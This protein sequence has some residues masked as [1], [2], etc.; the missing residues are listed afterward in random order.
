METTEVVKQNGDAATRGISRRTVMKGAAWS[1]PVIA[2]AAA[3]PMATA[4]C[5]PTGGVLYF[6]GI[7]DRS[8]STGPVTAEL[9]DCTGVAATAD[10]LSQQNSEMVLLDNATGTWWFA[11]DPAQT[12]SANGCGLLRTVTGTPP[13]E[14][15]W[16]GQFGID[17][18][19]NV[20]MANAIGGTST[21]ATA[22]L[23]TGASNIVQVYDSD[24]ASTTYGLDASGAVWRLTGSVWYPVIRTATS[25][26]GQLVVDS[27]ADSDEVYGN[28]IFISTTGQVWST[29]PG[30]QASPF[31]Q[32][33]PS[34]PNVVVEV[35]GYNSG[36]NERIFARDSDGALWSFNGSSW[37]K[38]TDGPISNLTYSPMSRAMYVEDG[39]LYYVDSLYAPINVPQEYTNLPAGFDPNLIVDTVSRAN[40]AGEGWY[41]QLS[42]GTWWSSKNVAGG[43][44]QVIGTPGNTVTQITQDG[45]ALAGTGA[46]C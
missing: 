1:L 24:A 43:V 35:V 12:T 39:K 40:G 37:T 23:I 5:I 25:G 4:S 17:A 11:R 34:S 26:G 38:V 16:A 19:G 8:D 7:G 28:P 42:D 22:T 21:T 10:V 36:G 13:I 46:G 15:I 41:A 29:S 31:P 32:G 9:Y 30:G 14:S 2:A 45:F 3:A 27:M 6:V 18:N 20:Y 44:Y 33:A